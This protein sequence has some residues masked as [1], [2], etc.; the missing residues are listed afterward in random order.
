MSRGTFHHIDLTVSDVAM[1]KPVYALVL[2]IKLELV[3]APGWI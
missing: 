2:G 1:A 3:Y